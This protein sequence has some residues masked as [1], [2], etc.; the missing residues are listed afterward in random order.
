[1]LCLT[2]YALLQ[3]FQNISGK[4][5]LYFIIYHNVLDTVLNARNK[6]ERSL[7]SYGQAGKHGIM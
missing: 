7:F 5:N 6:R 2:P 1:M 4:I 3:L